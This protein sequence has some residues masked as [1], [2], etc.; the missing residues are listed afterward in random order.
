[1]SGSDVIIF[2]KKRPVVVVCAVIALVCLGVL[3]FRWDEIDA[4]KAA[5]DEAFKADQEILANVR[6]AASLPQQIET[7]QR[8]TK[9]LESRLVHAGQLAINL[10]YFY[11]LEN[12]TGV[13]LVDVR[14]NQIGRP[15]K[16]LYIGVPYNVTVQ[17]SFPHVMDFMRRL[18]SGRH[19][20]RFNTL[21]FSKIAGADAGGDALSVAM[22]VELL[23]TP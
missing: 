19:F 1:M 8:A 3:Y 11:R 9:N 16:A 20:A 2:V 5:Y 13:K 17:G 7:I 23:G 21:S 14:Q 15:S 12:D 10:Q 22:N 4:S 18:E 6:N